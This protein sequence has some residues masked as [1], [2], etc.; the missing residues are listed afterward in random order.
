MNKLHPLTLIFI[1][2]AFLAILA[3]STLWSLNTLFSLQI[4]V[5]WRNLVAIVILL[6]VINGRTK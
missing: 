1:A 2:I 6:A 5:N 3:Y 4:E